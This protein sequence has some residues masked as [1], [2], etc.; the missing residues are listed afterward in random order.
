M[1]HTYKFNN[2]SKARL[3][4][5]LITTLF[6]LA[7]TP[8]RAQTDFVV[9]T[10]KGLLVYTG[11]HIPKN[12]AYSI[13]RANGLKEPFKQVATIKVKAD[14]QLLEKELNKNTVL[15]PFAK[16]SIE[17]N[18]K[19]ILNYALD[20]NSAGNFRYAGFPA[21]ALTLGMAYLDVSAVKGTS[22]IYRVVY[23]A[24]DGSVVTE[25]TSKPVEAGSTPALQNIMPYSK[26]E[27]AEGVMIHWYTL[28]PGNMTKM[29][30][31]NFYRRVHSK[32]EYKKLP[33]D[34]QF[35]SAPGDTVMIGLYDTTAAPGGIYQYVLRPVDI[36]SNEGSAT[37]PVEAST[38][39]RLYG[40]DFTRLEAKSLASGYMIRLSWQAGPMTLARGIEIYR[41][42]HYDTGY[43]RVATVPAI[44]TFYIDRVDRAMESYF[45]YLAVLGP[46]G[47]SKPGMRISAIYN[48]SDK[49]LPPLDFTGQ[50]VVEGVELTFRSEEPYIKG[51]YV[52]RSAGY[53][54]ELKQISDLVV[55]GGEWVTYIDS[56][57]A[58]NGKNTY[59]YA[60]KTFSETYQL[61]DF[62]EKIMV[63]PGTP[64]HIRAPRNLMANV[65]PLE[66]SLMWEDLSPVEDILAGYSI[67]RKEK[68]KKD[69]VPLYKQNP[70]S[71]ENYFT[72]STAIPGK[73]YEYAIK[74]FD[75]FGAESSYSMP[76]GVSFTGYFPVSPP[77]PEARASDN[78]VMVSWGKTS[79]PTLE[80]YRIYRYTQTTKPVLIGSTDKNTLYLSDKNVKKG[81]TYFYYITSF[82]KYNQESSD[83]KSVSIIY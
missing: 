14:Y 31:V 17:A 56:S 48:G 57:E 24:D 65:T 76:L 30:Q 47:R 9:P 38:T 46:S 70:V 23:R 42:N 12:G 8:V 58:I 81:V 49:P 45:Y 26:Q 62:S 13:E 21:V 72:D 7:L 2:I 25:K 1:I 15:F 53:E 5:L 80:G 55:P 77:A 59:T 34:A 44:D 4:T 40:A 27:S 69:W 68:D 28:K 60:V 52:Y 75:L 18:K 22:Y 19:E 20:N 43:Y 6:C 66:V 32:G 36:Y 79:Y 50:P 10:P 78:D 11:D 64:T 35:H 71:Y 41:S 33:L 29:A 16:E 73:S 74:A 54:S 67:Y 37:P 61:S 51:Y 63:R 83:Y 3:N 82:D 39:G